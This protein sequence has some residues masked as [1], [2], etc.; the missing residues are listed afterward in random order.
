MVYLLTISDIR[1][2][3]S[4]SEGTG[5]RSYFFVSLGYCVINSILAGI[6]LFKSRSNL[7]SKF[8]AFSV[9][10]LVL[11]GILWFFLT[12]PVAMLHMTVLEQASAFIYALFP[13]FFLHF[14]LIFLRRYDVVS[15]PKV[16]LATYF[17]GMFCYTLVLLGQIPLPFSQSLGVNATGYVYFVTWMSML[18]A[19]GVAL[20]YSLI[21]GFAERG[22]GSNLLFIAVA[23]LM[24]M[25]PTPFT[26]SI[27]SAISQN[28]FVPY[29]ISSTLSLTIIV[30]LVFRHRMTMNAPYQAMKSA[31]SAMND[32]IIKTNTDYEIDMVQGAIVP[33]LGHEIS[34]I[35]GKDLR[36]FLDDAHLLE[37][38]RE[39]VL[40]EK[41]KEHFFNTNVLC[42]DGTKM[43]MEFSFTPV[44]GNEEIVGFVGVGRNIS[45]RRRAEQALQESESRYRLLFESN[46]S[47]MLVYD[48]ESLRFFLVNAAA[49]QHYGYSM[50]EFLKLTVSDIVVAGASDSGEQQHRRKDGSLVEVE[51]NAH[52]FVFGHR[53]A[54][55]IMITDITQRKRAEEAIRKS[56]EKYRR[57]FEEDLT[58]YMCATPDGN[59]KTCNPA[60]A[61]IFGLPST[62]EALRTNLRLLYPSAKSFEAQLRQL[63]KQRMLV[64]REEQLRSVDGQ[65]V[66]II[67]NMIGTFNE[68][69]GLTEI[70]AYIFDNTERK[71]LEDE[72]RHAQ[73]MENLGSLAGGIAHDFNN[74]LAIIS[75]HASILKKRLPK[76][77]K[78]A[79]NVEALSEAGTRAAAL[80]RQLLTFARRTEVVFEP[81]NVN[82][83]IR[84]LLKML[85]PTL[86]KTIDIQVR[87]D[88]EIP[89]I[90]ADSNQLHQLLLNLCVNAR[91]A[92]P[93]G[94]T[95][96]IR[97]ESVS[98]MDVREKFPDAQEL[99]YVSISMTDTGTGM[100]E[101]TRNR[102]FEPFF[103]TKGVGKGTGLGLAVVYG[104]VS[105]D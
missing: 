4:F 89:T 12:N 73:K 41:V 55:L 52:A 9:G 32:V 39:Q 29:F 70:R 13:F 78:L 46:P 26:V 65:P 38:Y 7:L 6:I 67:Q 56:E 51:M 85:A 96:T 88:T 50:G 87:P 103:T 95:L 33:L 69:G 93:S 40:A 105:G 31:L 35:L 49:V 74:I 42:K 63:R 99:Q 91:D 60:F 47:P 3:T 100:D 76:N 25:L 83:V 98:G 62:D 101:A 20:L 58:G 30:Y 59:I 66:N 43:P 57:Y 53:S 64:N 44:Y 16:I 80:V 82:A 61:R 45:E 97:T 8:Y 77:E 37:H 19:I 72:L 1:G 21:G 34:D 2:S 54:R 22:M 15:S 86:P 23:L 36:T 24:L 94:G 102:I 5:M 27:F 71:K 68:A 75:V 14:M 104:I 28:S 84:E 90:P 11:L 92:M 18:F 81:V 17:V 10:I 79:E 48:L